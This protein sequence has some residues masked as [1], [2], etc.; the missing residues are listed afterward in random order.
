MAAAM[1]AVGLLAFGVAQAGAE[2]PIRVAE[3]V[4]DDG[5]F[6]GFGRSRDVDEDALIAAVAAAEEAGLQL[7]VVVPRDPQPS[8]KAFAR[9]VQER[10]EAEVAVVLPMDGPLELYVVEE[11]SS[12]RAR[13][14]DM[15]RRFDEPERAIG[16]LTEELTTEPVIERPPI[17][18]RII[19]ALIL[20]CIVIAV[21]VM[22]ELGVDRLRR[23]AVT[24]S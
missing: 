8:A 13:A 18:D 23:G 14:L 2:S 20:F 3:A 1:A 11:L 7:V 10:T 17:L 5:V 4:A 15:A 19:D 16:A 22:I 9:R 24:A 6:V 21:V 12:S